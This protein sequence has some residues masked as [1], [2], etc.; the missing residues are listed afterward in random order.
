MQR[1]QLLENLTSIKRRGLVLRRIHRG[2]STGN[3]HMFTHRKVLGTTKKFVRRINV[4]FSAR[5]FPDSH[6]TEHGHKATWV[7]TERFMRPFIAAGTSI[8]ASTVGQ[9]YMANDTWKHGWTYSCV[10][11]R[12]QR[13]LL[14]PCQRLTRWTDHY[15]WNW[16]LPWKDRNSHRCW[17]RERRLAHKQ[18][19]S[20][21]NNQWISRS[22]QS[23]LVI[24]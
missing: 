17:A 12:N 22:W 15:W 16:T 14:F 3:R 6:R 21:K 4:P 5:L 1:L 24:I 7:Q 18:P 13:Y 9:V 8:T 2:Q 20:R 10:C 19:K 23:M 11:V